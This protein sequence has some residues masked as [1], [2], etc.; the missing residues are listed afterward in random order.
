MG[1]FNL[2]A[3]K[4]DCVL[5]IYVHEKVKHVLIFVVLKYFGLVYGLAV[6]N[7]AMNHASHQINKKL[8][9]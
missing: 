7:K 6:S 1:A 2:F 4:N 9:C 8:G 3:D 5:T